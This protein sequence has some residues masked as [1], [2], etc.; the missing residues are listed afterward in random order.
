M[1]A[2]PIVSAGAASSIVLVGQAPGKRVHKTGIPWNDRSGDT[3]RKWLQLSKEVFYN[4]ELVTLMPMGFCYPGTGK[5]GDLPPRP[6]C[7]PLWHPQLLGKLKKVQLTI[8][9]G[10]YAQEYYLKNNLRKT[11]TETVK[12]Y[13][14]Y[15]PAYFPLPHP[16]PRNSGWFTKNPWF[17]G[18]VLPQLRE[19][20]S[21]ILEISN[22]ETT[23]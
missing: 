2:N 19:L 12:N 15:L 17:E 22:Q 8:L 13:T 1:G 10:R 16:S 11:L 9:I 21:Q 4:P 18:T 23:A 20:V 7:A 6:E 14:A 3:L 5:S